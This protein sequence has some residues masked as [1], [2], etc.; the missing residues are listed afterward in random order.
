MVG[1]S[2]SKTRVKR[3]YV[4]SLKAID[5]PGL[6]LNA[7]RARVRDEVCRL[8]RSADHAQ[9]PAVYDKLIGSTDVYLAAATAERRAQ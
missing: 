7:L 1:Y 5:T 6:S 8:A 9:T 4:L 3:A 2:A